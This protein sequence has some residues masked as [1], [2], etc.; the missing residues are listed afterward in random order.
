M[1]TTSAIGILAAIFTTIASFPQA[2]KIIKQKTS[3]GVSAA[4][5]LVLLIGTLLW[6]VYG[7]MQSDW[8]II[9]ANSIS[10]ILSAIILI[11]YR[12]SDKK[13]KKLN[14][15]LKSAAK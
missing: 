6:L 13:I 12:V 14:Q 10:S 8:P 3:K 5:Y 9:V 7:I 1:D 15:V 2:Y 11:L 4:T